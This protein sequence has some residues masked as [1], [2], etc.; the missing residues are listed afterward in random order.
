MKSLYLLCSFCF[1]V[2]SHRLAAQSSG[3]IQV[4][5]N[6]SNI[7]T[8]PGGSVNQAN[9]LRTLHAGVIGDLPLGGSLYLQPGLIYTGKGS[10]VQSGAEGVNGHFRQTFNP[11]Y[12][13]IP[14]S[15]VIKSPSSGMGRFFAGAG[16]YLAVGIRGK[17]KTE[18]RTLLG[19]NYKIERDIQ[20]S[21]DDPITLTEEEGAGFGIIKRFDYGLNAVVGFEGKSMVLSA[22]YGLGLAKIHSGAGSGSDENNK[23]RV[24]S[25]SLGFKF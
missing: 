6:L 24:L 12:L 9:S 22:G 23:F 14:V 7:S 1:L 8:S 15:L 4:G 2:L 3:R 11:Y 16:P 25:F 5:L 13:E 17:T 18:G 19:I 10:K 21:N 20:F